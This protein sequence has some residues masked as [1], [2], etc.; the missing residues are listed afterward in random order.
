M[1]HFALP[2]AEYARDGG[3]RY[4]RELREKMNYGDASI[5]VLIGELRKMTKGSCSAIRAKLVGGASVIEALEQA[6]EIGALNISIAERILDEYGIVITARDVGGS[7]GRKVHFHTATGRLRVAPV[8]GQSREPN[9]SGRTQREA[10]SS[11]SEGRHARR[12]RVLVVDDSKTMRTLLSGILKQDPLLE[13]VATASD[14]KEAEAMISRFDPDVMTLDVQLPGMDGVA[15][16]ENLL[17]RRP[18][19]VV[20]ITSLNIRESGL[21]I[22][23]LELGAVDYIQKPT[24]SEVAVVGPVIREKVRSAAEARIRVPPRRAGEAR[25]P[26]AAG[27]GF[28]KSALIAIGSS[29]GGTEALKDVLLGLPED[30]PPIVAVQHIP[31]VFS[32]AFAARL[33]ELCPFEVKEAEHGDL[34]QP[35][36]VLIAPGGRQ[37]K[38]V[39]RGINLRIELNDSPPVN[40]HRPSVDYLFDSVATHVGKN[41]I[42]VILTGMGN[43]GARGLLKMR[44]AGAHTIAQD[45]ASCVVFGMPREAIRLGAIEVVSGLEDIPRHLLKR[46]R[47]SSPRLSD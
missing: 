12:K 37:M 38:I 14:V 34:V 17:P 8:N 24:S 29:T 31:A 35:G 43:D 10:L 1:N 18:L 32:K 26:I 15:F 42:G 13:V 30:I 21:V 4:G 11:R 47:E 45:E 27:V 16:L 39:R 36:R 40:R 7:G 2:S 28:G 33:N 23:A 19:P 44:I 20:M 6:S 25:L 5:P 22:R 3:G 41:A 46:T 9:V